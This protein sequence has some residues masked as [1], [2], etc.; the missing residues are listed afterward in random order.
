MLFAK[1]I[2]SKGN[3]LSFKSGK[4][5]RYNAG[6]YRKLQTLGIY[7]ILL[8]LLLSGFGISFKCDDSQFAKLSKVSEAKN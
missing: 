4:F 5:L 3:G 2:P 1:I 8:R 6:N 7:T